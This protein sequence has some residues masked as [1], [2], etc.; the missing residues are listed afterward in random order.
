MTDRGMNYF[1]YECLVRVQEQY[2][3]L[4][5]DNGL[6][7]VQTG[8]VNSVFEKEVIVYVCVCLWVSVYFDFE[9]GITVYEFPYGVFRSLVRV[10]ESSVTF[11]AFTIVE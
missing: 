10:V 1:T 11:S 3:Y 5:V 9:R 4:F 6:F 2:K 8:S 7:V